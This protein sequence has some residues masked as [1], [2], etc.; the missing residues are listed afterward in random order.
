MFS[1]QL[2]V[3]N[4]KQ[5]QAIS[6][7]PYIV[8]SSTIKQIY[9]MSTSTRKEIGAE[10]R[11][12]FGYVA[13]KFPFVTTTV[14]ASIAWYFAVPT[15]DIAFSILFSA[16]LVMAN[17]HRFQYNTPAREKDINLSLLKEDNKFPWFTVYMLI[18]TTAGRLAPT[19]TL[20]LGPSEVKNAVAPH[21]FLLLS[22]ITMEGV[23]NDVRYYNLIR[24]LVPIGFNAYRISSLL[25]WVSMAWSST[26]LKG[27]WYYWLLGLAIT[28]LVL[29]TY[30][31]FI[32]LL[33]R[34]TPAYLDPV[35]SPAAPVVW[36]FQAIPIIQQQ[37]KNE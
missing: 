13:L 37:E 9:N 21:L 20:I 30:N 18:F 23:S 7:L 16:Y 32:V 6:I 31:L 34:V 8:P 25:E 10:K 28:N 15:M 3:E 19:V 11:L 33:L 22:Q 36:K 14:T 1:S 24:L 12:F 5:D 2:C 4:I 17:I 35:V 27:F 26:A 29:W